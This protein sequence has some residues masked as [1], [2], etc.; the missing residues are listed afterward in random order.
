MSTL[1]VSGVRAAGSALVKTAGQVALSYANSAIS[2][3]FDNRTFEGPRLSEFHLMTSRDGAPMPRC[4]GRVRLAGQVIWASRLRESATETRQGGKGGGPTTKQYS[5][6]ISFALGMCEGEIQSV[7]RFWVNGAPLATRDLTY[8]IHKGGEMQAVDPVIAATEGPKAPAFRG[9]AY[10]VFED[11]P[12]DDYGARL[13]QFNAE[14]MRLPPRRSADDGLETLVTGMHFLPSSGE[15]AYAPEIVEDITNPAEARPLN[16]NNLSGAADIVRAVDQLE[17]ALPACRNISIVISW[18]GSDLHAGTCKI[19]PGVESDYRVL[20]GDVEWSVGSVMRDEAYIVSRDGKDRPVYGGTPSDGS[21][22]AA[23]AHLKARGFSVMIYPFILMDIDQEGQPRFPWRGRIGSLDAAQDADSAVDSFFGQAAPLD[24]AVDSDGIDYDGPDEDSFRRFILHYAQLAKVAGGVDRFIIGSEMVDLTRLKTPNGNYPAVAAL[25]SLAADVRSILP[26]AQLS[27]AAD[28]TEYFGDQRDGDVSY[29]LD[30]LWADSNIDAVGIDAYFPL[31][32]WREGTQHLDASLTDSPYN[33]AYLS[34]NI[35]GGEGY[36]WYYA[37]DA[38]RV[39]QIRS[40]ITDGSHGQPWVYRYKDLRNWWTHPHVN[41][42][43]GAETSTSP[44]VP[45]SKPIWLTEIG[46]PAIHLGANQPNVFY[47]PKSSESAFPHHSDGTRDDLIQRRY[48]EAMLDYWGKNNPVSPVYNGHM[49]DIDA[50]HVWCWDARPYPD[51]PARSDIWADG[52]NWQRGHWLTGRVGAILVAD[53]VYDLVSAAGVDSVAT[54]AIGGLI[55][56]YMIDRPMPT[57]AAL[58]PLALAY[59]FELIETAQGLSFVSGL[60]PVFTLDMDDIASEGGAAISEIKSDPEGRLRDVRLRFVDGGRDH[61]SGS[62]SARERSAE[63]VNVLDIDLPIVMDRQFARFTARRL[64]TA[65]K[66]LDRTL[67]FTLSP[68]RSDLRIGDTLALPGIDGRWRIESYDGPGAAQIKARIIDEGA[69][70]LSNAGG[71]PVSPAPIIWAPKPRILALDIPGGFFVGAMQRPFSA[72]T[73]YTH[74][75]EASVT[76]SEPVYFGALTSSLEP[77]PIGRWDRARAFTFVM[78]SAGL[79]SIDPSQ[80]LAGGNRFAI[81]TSSGWEILIAQT[82]TLIG[83][84]E[85]RASSLLRGLKGSDADMEFVSEGAQIV[86]LEK[87]LAALPI[88][89]AHIGGPITL[90]A[91]AAGRESEALNLDYV[92]RKNRPLSPVHGKAVRGVGGVTVNWVRRTREGGDSWAGLDVPLGE[93][94]PLF[95]VQGFLGATLFDEITT[96]ETFAALNLTDIDRVHVAQGSRSFGY[97][98]VL[99][100]TLPPPT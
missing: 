80:A 83:A 85:Y 100:I 73:I 40:P 41:R 54:G 19:R 11:F 47:D 97:G 30:P 33:K 86:W 76:V 88:D 17:D 61:Q 62:A 42:E 57:R 53:V 2:R 67:A 75:G 58:S 25:Q 94:N 48:L 29:H 46:C 8:R 96:T 34:A 77:G 65:S 32:D 89:E 5:Y 6:T 15:F 52:Q 60:G 16:M 82:L 35:E 7:D 36:D 27:Y 23:I 50:V 90:K 13:P 10:V 37:S 79:A 66:Q 20:D 39:G 92:G 71:T 70:A 3:L 78:P 95:R 87:G 55:D 24:F 63:T 81:E 44:W 69:P 56:G 1:I 98:P 68:A 18:F 14:V 49:I 72:T 93:E 38:D 26:D 43:N 59:D 28:W 22:L 4:F 84:D 45:K 74:E 12:L 51:F 21:I 31:A 9:T 91:F 64:L 99:E